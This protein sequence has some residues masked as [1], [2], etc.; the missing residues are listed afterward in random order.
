MIGFNFTLFALTS[1]EVTSVNGVFSYFTPSDLLYS[2][3]KVA[4]LIAHNQEFMFLT[5]FL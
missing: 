1:N 4:K 5:F 2:A 3:L